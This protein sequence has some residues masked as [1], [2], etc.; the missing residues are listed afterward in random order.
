M[1][2]GTYGI[3][4]AVTQNHPLLL[5]QKAGMNTK[6]REIPTQLTSESRRLHT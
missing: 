3:I 5:P 4:A 1:G 2:R 6:K